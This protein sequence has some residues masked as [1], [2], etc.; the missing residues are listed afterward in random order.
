LLRNAAASPK[1]QATKKEEQKGSH[2]VRTTTL[3]LNHKTHDSKRER[4]GHR[5]HG[6]RRETASERERPP[7]P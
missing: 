6:R 2:S 3:E 7:G 1:N 5:E 4:G